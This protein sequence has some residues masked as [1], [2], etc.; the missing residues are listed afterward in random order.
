MFPDLADTLKLTLPESNRHSKQ[1]S[2]K[3]TQSKTRRNTHTE[4]DKDGDKEKETY[5]D[6][7]TQQ[8]Y[9]F[10]SPCF[11]VRTATRRP[12]NLVIPPMVSTHR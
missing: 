1:R 3:E 4:I 11:C 10:Q 12:Q 9:E 5:Y 6:S 2:D 8:A 7:M